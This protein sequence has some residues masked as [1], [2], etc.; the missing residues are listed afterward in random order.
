MSSQLLLQ[1]SEHFSSEEKLEN[2]LVFFIKY[3]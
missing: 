1:E 3:E 2:N